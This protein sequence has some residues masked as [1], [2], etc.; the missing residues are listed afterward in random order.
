[1]EVIGLNSRESLR[2]YIERVEKLEEEIKAAKSDIKEIYAEAKGEGF[3]VKIMKAIVKLRAK[4]LRGG[5]MEIE[6]AQSLLDTYLAA[7]G[8]LPGGDDVEIGADVANDAAPEP[9]P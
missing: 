8:W 7:L 3:D 2:T 1:M 9:V 6:T 4:G 5:L